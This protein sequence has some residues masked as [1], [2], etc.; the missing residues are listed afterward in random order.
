MILIYIVEQMIK[1][2]NVYMIIFFLQTEA[3]GSI[4]ANCYV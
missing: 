4:L 2:Q 3:T 1:F